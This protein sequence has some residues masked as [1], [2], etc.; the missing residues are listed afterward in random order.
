VRIND[1]VAVARQYAT[2]ANLEARRSLYAKADGPDPRQVAFEAVA[3]CAPERVLEVGGG[4]GELAARISSELGCDTV[5]LDI[6]PRMVE[7]ARGRGVDALVGDV[8]ELPFDDGSFDCAVAAWMLFHVP[9]IDRGLAELARVLRPGGRLVAVTNSERHLR[10]LRAIAGRAA[11][12]RVFTR[13]NGA[14]ALGRHF[15]Q[16]ERR[17]ADGWITIEDHE[18]VRRFVASLDADEPVV[19]EPYELP[20][21]SRRASSVFVATRV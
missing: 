4:P 17:D 18:T 9:E 16:V 8:T 5:M 13:E 21:R 10:E 12:A 19:P 20:I 7:L 14:E 2:E 6:S 3:E 15:G 11:W 1:P